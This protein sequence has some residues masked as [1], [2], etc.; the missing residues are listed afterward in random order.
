M[1]IGSSA[2]WP[3]HKRDCL[4]DYYSVMKGDSV[5]FLCPK[6]I[7]DELDYSFLGHLAL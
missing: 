1:I 3:K 4:T 2:L 7:M 6:L 5:F